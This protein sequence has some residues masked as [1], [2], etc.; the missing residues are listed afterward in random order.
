MQYYHIWTKLTSTPFSFTLICHRLLCS[1][2]GKK[3]TDKDGKPKRNKEVFIYICVCV[4]IFIYECVFVV[5]ECMDLHF[6]FN[7]A[8]QRRAVIYD[9]EIHIL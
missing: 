4:Y 7:Y 1:Y 2:L 5:G 6:F 9:N 8:L 3:K